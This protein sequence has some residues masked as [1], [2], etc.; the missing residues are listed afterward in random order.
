MRRAS[1]SEVLGERFQR[2]GKINRPARSQTRCLHHVP[3]GDVAERQIREE[4]RFGDIIAHLLPRLAHHLGYCVVG[5][6]H[7]FGIAGGARCVNNREQV[8]HVRQRISRHGFVIGQHIAPLHG[9]RI[10]G[11]RTG[12]VTR[13]GNPVNGRRYACF[14]GIPT[15]QLP[16]KQHPAF[17]VLQYLPKL[18]PG[19]RWVERHRH[20]TAH[21]N[22][23]IGNNPVSAVFGNQS[24]V[25]FGRQTERVEV[26][27]HDA[28]LPS[29]LGPRD[30]DK[31]VAHGL[32]QENLFR[33]RLLPV[34]EAANERIQLLIDANERFHRRGQNKNGI[35]GRKINPITS[36]IYAELCQTC[37]TQVPN[38]EG[39]G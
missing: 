2:F 3:F 1:Y 22:G 6:H 10:D 17:A 37:K 26:G 24:D 32:A 4:P 27:G 13:K 11:G 39:V 12:R 8:I 21:Q 7:P 16:H 35:L 34:V 19:E 5:H 33:L 23:Q 25:A 38:P 31:G 14:N 36:E 18:R 30:I 9:L 15:I 29:G 20:V 28:G